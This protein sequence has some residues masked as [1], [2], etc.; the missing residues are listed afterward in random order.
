MLV[1][2]DVD[3]VDGAVDEVDGAVDDCEE[4]EHWMAPIR[5]CNH[6]TRPMLRRHIGMGWFLTHNLPVWP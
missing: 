5:D 6:L 4:G 3:E 1:P 2:V